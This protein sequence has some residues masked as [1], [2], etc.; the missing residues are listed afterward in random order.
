MLP[1]NIAEPTH[2]AMPTT[3][4]PW[5]MTLRLNLTTTHLPI[6]E[7]PGIQSIHQPSNRPTECFQQLLPK[8]F[9]K[10]TETVLIEGNESERLPAMPALWSPHV[11]GR[12]KGFLLQ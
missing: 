2:A 12:A 11:P 9:S 5:T 1:T 6:L 3:Q 7:P 8:K 10:Q 4:K